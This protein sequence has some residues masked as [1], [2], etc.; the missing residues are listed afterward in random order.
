MIRACRIVKT[1]RAASAFDGEGARRSG[2]RW[3]SVGTRIVYLGGSIALCAL[4]VLVHLDDA[5]LSAAYSFLPLSFPASCVA[6]PGKNG[7]APLPPNWSQIPA[8]IECALYG[9]AWI[10]S[11]SS[12]ILRVPSVIVPWESNYLLHPAH[13]DFSLAKIG[14]AQSFAF[15]ARLLDKISDEP[16]D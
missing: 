4:E 2:G 1:K 11:N 16:A 14:A 10:A 13:P 6:V 8:P 3:N 9:D 15:D 12:L 5:S 7:V